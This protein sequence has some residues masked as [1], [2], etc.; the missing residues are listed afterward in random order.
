MA[1]MSL[2][3]STSIEKK[4]KTNRSTLKAQR[5]QRGRDVLQQRPDGPS[6]N[7]VYSRSRDA[8]LCGMMK[9]LGFSSRTRRAR[10]GFRVF[11][12][13]LGSES[14]HHGRN[15]GGPCP[16]LSIL[17]ASME[18]CFDVD[19]SSP[20]RGILCTTVVILRELRTAITINFNVP[21]FR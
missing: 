8:W 15:S 18:K 3:A 17:Q 14:P 5:L 20:G 13:E 16:S 2:R 19:G 1:T 11:F 21:H 7:L 6:L 10:E 4:R 9:V 12:M